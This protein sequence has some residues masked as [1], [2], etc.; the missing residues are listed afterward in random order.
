MKREREREVFVEKQVK[1]CN[2]EICSFYIL[3]ATAPRVSHRS[4]R[5]MMQ[6]CKHMIVDKPTVIRRIVYYDTS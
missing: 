4:L 6:L 1:K 3:I 5:R 2:V